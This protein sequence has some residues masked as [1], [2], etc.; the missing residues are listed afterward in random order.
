MQCGCGNA[1]SG[2]NNC[3]FPDLDHSNLNVQQ[4]VLEYIDFATKNLKITGFRWDQA[5]GF[6]PQY[7][8]KYDS[9]GNPVFSVGEFYDGNLQNIKPFLAGSNYKLPVF[10]FPLVFILQKA[11]SQNSF[12][13]LSNPAAVLSFNSSL[14][15]TFIS[16][17][18][19]YRSTPFGN[20]NQILQ[21][22]AYILTHPGVPCVFFGDYQNSFLAPS[23]MQLMAL[24][25]SMG[26]HHNSRMTVD[27]A[28][29]GK[30]AAYIQGLNGSLAVKI[31]TDYWVPTSSNFTLALTGTNF[32]IW[33]L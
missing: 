30:Y 10:D 6:S 26:I 1:D 2:E 16:N 23:I 18:D 27:V 28:T 24:R 29:N 22:Y 5:K 9:Y 20:N 7:F 4:L 15:V 32:Q 3:S 13:S 21:G 33:T 31:G 12:Q 14:A 8:E 25:V 17:H 11:I 19:L